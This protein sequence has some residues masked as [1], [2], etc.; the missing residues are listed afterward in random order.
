MSCVYI[1]GKWRQTRFSYICWKRWLTGPTMKYKENSISS[2]RTSI[3]GKNG[4]NEPKWTSNNIH[5]WREYYLNPWITRVR[6]SY[7]DCLLIWGGGGE[8]HQILDNW[9]YT[10]NCRRII[11]CIFCR[12]PDSDYSCICLH[13]LIVSFFS[14]SSWRGV[15]AACDCGTQWTFLLTFL[16]NDVHLFL[17][18]IEVWTQGVV[19]R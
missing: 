13:A 12:S 4:N 17:K 8:V 19:W 5:F 7:A 14:S 16:S 1:L 10:C 18:F 11:V 3:S 6:L 9:I 15:A 2:T